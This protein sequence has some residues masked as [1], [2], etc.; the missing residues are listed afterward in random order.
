MTGSRSRA[1]PS[2]EASKS[3]KVD[4][5]DSGVLRLGAANRPRAEKAHREVSAPDHRPRRYC[6]PSS[7]G[8]RSGKALGVPTNGSPCPRAPAP[9]ATVSSIDRQSQWPWPGAASIPNFPKSNR[10]LLS[11][12]SSTRRKTAYPPSFHTREKDGA[13]A[14][15]DPVARPSRS[16]RQSPPTVPRGIPPYRGPPPP[17]PMASYRRRMSDAKPSPTKG[18]AAVRPPNGLEETEH[19][20]CGVLDGF[21]ERPRRSVE[22]GR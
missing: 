15:F 2:W 9:A 11:T 6:G 17:P 3:C 21:G 22:G 5:R 19:S 13:S 14:A 4:P 7:R 1:Y 10:R 16:H 12:P 8:N 20:P 18:I